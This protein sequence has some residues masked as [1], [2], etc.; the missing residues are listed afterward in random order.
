M[1]YSLLL[2]D[3]MRHGAIEFLFEVAV[4]AYLVHA[5]NQILVPIF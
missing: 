2:L 4:I 3:H 5:E 1:L